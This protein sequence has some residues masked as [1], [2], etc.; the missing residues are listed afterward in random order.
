MA[1]LPGLEVTQVQ[2][3]YLIAAFE[4]RAQDRGLAGAAEAYQAFQVE[5]LVALVRERER[6]G[7]VEAIREAEAQATAAA[8]AFVSAL[9]NG[10]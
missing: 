2:F 10:T 1:T 3:D 4:E 9:L 7:V 8:E 6:V 5:N